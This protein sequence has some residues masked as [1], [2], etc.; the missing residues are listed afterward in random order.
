M[1][2]CTKCKPN[3]FLVDSVDDLK[4]CVTK[5]ID[6][7]I[8]YHGDGLCGLFK[9]QVLLPSKPVIINRISGC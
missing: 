8:L 7:C 5:L 3:Y 9:P 4:I 1:S 2:D 6:N